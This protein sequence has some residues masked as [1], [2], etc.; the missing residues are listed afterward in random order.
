MREKAA[1]PRLLEIQAAIRNAMLHGDRRAVAPFLIGG[2]A[3]EH[4]F[5]IHQRHYAASLAKALVERFPAT[6]WLAGSELVTDAAR[7][8]IREQ[9]PTKPCIGEYGDGFPHHLA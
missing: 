1:M 8:F 4:R 6:V 7:S 3:A 5:A 9:P 2:A